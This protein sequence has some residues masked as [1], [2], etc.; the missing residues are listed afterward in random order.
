MNPARIAKIRALADDERGDPATRARAQ[1]KLDAYRLSHPHLFEQPKHKFH[2]VR[3][4]RRVHGMRLDPAYE[5]Y[6][7][8]D[9]SLWSQTKAGNRTHTVYH[10]GINYRIV[11]F[12]H[13]KSPTWGWMRVSDYDGTVFSGRF[14]TIGE[15]Q[16]DSWTS[17]MAI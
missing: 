6:I 13:K 7:F 1:E 3:Q 14:K 4:D 2:D 11:L 5:Y 12:Q 16:A 10:K 15:A 17:L 8:T 9:L